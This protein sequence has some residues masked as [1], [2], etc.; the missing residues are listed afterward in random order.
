MP[1]RALQGVVGRSAICPAISTPVGPAHDGE[2]QQPLA[3][4]GR[5][6]ARPLEGAQNP[7]SQLE[8]VV[9]GL[10]A[11][12]E[13]GE[14]VVAE[15]GLAGARGDDQA[16]VGGFVAV[17]EKVGDDDLVREIDVGDVAEQHFDVALPA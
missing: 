6:T 15:V 7:A 1:E 8:R 10:H 9:D 13:F 4:L 12:R 2:R 11:G 14:M 5:W 17:A 3:P 16:V